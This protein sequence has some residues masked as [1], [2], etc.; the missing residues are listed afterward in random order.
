MP[1]LREGVE[2][3]YLSVDALWLR[4]FRRRAEISEVQPCKYCCAGSTFHRG[5][6]EE[7]SNCCGACV[8][9]L[10]QGLALCIALRSLQ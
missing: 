10:L 9:A 1:R 2:V 8:L 7:G 3:K 6:L 5:V 4:R